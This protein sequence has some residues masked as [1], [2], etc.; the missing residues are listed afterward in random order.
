MYTER[1]GTYVDGH[2]LVGTGGCEGVGECQFKIRRDAQEFCDRQSDCNAVLL[3]PFENNCAGGLGCYTPRH[4]EA[5]RKANLWA[6]AGGRAW[7]KGP[8][9]RHEP[10]SRERSPYFFVGFAGA[11]EALRA[12]ATYGAHLAAPRTAEQRAALQAAL[13]AAEANGKLSKAWPK[14]TIWLGGIWN[15]SGERWEWQDGVPISSFDWAPGQPSAA[16]HQLDEPWLCMVLDGAMHDAEAGPNNRFG[17]MCELKDVLPEAAGHPPAPPAAEI[18][19]LGVTGTDQFLRVADAV[20]T[21]SAKASKPRHPS[22][23]P[24]SKPV[25]ADD[26]F[27]KPPDIHPWRCCSYVYAGMANCSEARGRCG[28]KQRL[29]MPKSAREYAALQEAIKAAL[30]A[31]NLSERWPHNTIWLGGSWRGGARK[32]W[33]W[34]DGSPI[35][36]STWR[37]GQ[38]SAKGHQFREPCLVQDLNG[39]IQDAEQYFEFG[40]VCEEATDDVMP[41]ALCRTDSP[42]WL[43][44]SL[45][46]LLLCALLARI[47]QAGISVCAPL[48]KLPPPVL[49]T[50]LPLLLFGSS[51]AFSLLF[52][53][54]NVPRVISSAPR[55]IAGQL[56]AV[57]GSPAGFLVLGLLASF[58]IFSSGSCV[59]SSHF[60]AS[61]VCPNG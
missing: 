6:R 41:G 59:G 20:A 3:H 37:P 8:S 29:A 49:L 40:V 30:E 44:T 58:W 34:D 9:I 31:G 19:S 12:C 26:D 35:D 24:A 32:Q 50:L 61:A 51:L 27:P 11:P 1:S 38:L 16:D 18:D 14:N 54:C 60:S 17:I 21:S 53:S 42:G 46:A 5:S 36:T 52:G 57:V 23:S 56:Q 55:S 15:M 25:V 2:Y 4:G 45:M 7:V 22:P 43:R 28:A 10:I 47:H 33:E 48:S 13:D 39:V